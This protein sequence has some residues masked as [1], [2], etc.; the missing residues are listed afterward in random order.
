MK[1]AAA[2]IGLCLTIPLIWAGSCNNE[3]VV[4]NC[5]GI[6]CT[7]MFAM[8]QLEVKNPQGEPVALQDFYTLRGK[9]A[10]PIRPEQQMDVVGNYVVLDDGYLAKLR[11]QTDSFTFIGVIDGEQVL[12]V[13]FKIGADCCHVGRQEG[14][15]EVI[16]P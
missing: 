11:Q 8:I 6:A 16:Y 13:P 4:Q 14:P 15:T 7:M 2:L 9:D 5:E 1:K 12:S 10:T 3:E